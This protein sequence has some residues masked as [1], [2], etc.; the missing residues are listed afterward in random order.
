MNN[1]T[2]VTMTLPLEQIAKL[3]AVAVQTGRSRS[4][5]ARLILGEALQLYPAPPPPDAFPDDWES[6]KNHDVLF[7][8]KWE[9]P[10]DGFIGEVNDEQQQ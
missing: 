9:S 1:F 5:V 2:R 6:M 3:D 4:A 7:P 10:D 8:E